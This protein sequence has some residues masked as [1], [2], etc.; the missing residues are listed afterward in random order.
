M[1]DKTIHNIEYDEQTPQPEG[2]KIVPMDIN[3]IKD[4]E[5]ELTAQV[6]TSSISVQELFDLQKGSQITLNETLNSPISLY[7]D[8]K[9][10]AEGKLVAIGD[11]FGI[12]ITDIKK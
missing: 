12:E 9:L 2:N 3:L 6:G 4:V 8:N 10:I 5:V 11:N 1:N 7:I